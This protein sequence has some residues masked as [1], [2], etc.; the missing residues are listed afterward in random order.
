MV[1]HSY[2]KS[3]VPFAS[4]VVKNSQANRQSKIFNRKELFLVVSPKTTLLTK[5]PLHAFPLRALSALCGSNLYH[6]LSPEYSQALI[7]IL[8]VNSIPTLR[9]RNSNLR[10][11]QYI[12][13]EILSCD[14]TSPAFSLA[15]IIV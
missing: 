9:Q 15:L 14:N 3:F 12:I 11:V 1:L 13:K 2:R 5:P 4:F 10:T 7:P 6:T 8:M